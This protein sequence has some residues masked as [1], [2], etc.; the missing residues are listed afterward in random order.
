MLSLTAIHVSTHCIKLLSINFKYPFSQQ[1]SLRFAPNSSAEQKKTFLDFSCSVGCS[2]IWR[3]H[4]TSCH[5][6]ESALRKRKGESN[7]TQRAQS[8]L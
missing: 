5:Y 1:A 6:N 3:A 8:R 7:A 4:P 2:E